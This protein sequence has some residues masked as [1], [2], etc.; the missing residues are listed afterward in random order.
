MKITPGPQVSSATYYLL[1]PCCLLLFLLMYRAIFTLKIIELKHICG[2]IYMWTPAETLMTLPVALF[3]FTC[4][5]TFGTPG[6]PSKEVLQYREHDF[7]PH[8]AVGSSRIVMMVCSHSL[9]P[10]AAPL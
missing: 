9:D 10:P 7:E 6:V 2:H 4:G 1:L 3:P 5:C 8:R